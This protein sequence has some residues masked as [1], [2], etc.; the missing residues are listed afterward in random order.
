MGS[1]GVTCNIK[2]PKPRSNTLASGYSALSKALI[3]KSLD[4]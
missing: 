3:G 1:G 2:V 4:S